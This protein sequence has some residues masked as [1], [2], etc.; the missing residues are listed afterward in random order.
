MVVLREKKL[1]LQLTGTRFRHRML[2]G[3]LKSSSFNAVVAVIAG[4]VVIVF[5]FFS[6][7]GIRSTINKIE[8]KKIHTKPKW[9]VNIQRTYAYSRRWKKGEIC[10]IHLNFATQ[11]L[12]KL[13]CSVLFMNVGM[14]CMHVWALLLLGCLSQFACYA[15]IVLHKWHNKVSSRV[16]DRVQFD[17]YIWTVSSIFIYMMD[18]CLR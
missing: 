14:L 3:I 9:T 13:V 10:W 5:I 15:A 16:N 1:E 11:C 2:C 7:N 4:A 12:I 18:R 8:V 6:L 17:I